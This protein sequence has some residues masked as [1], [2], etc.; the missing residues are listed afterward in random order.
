MKTYYKATRPDGTDFYSGT[1]DYAAHLKSGTPLDMKPVPRWGYHCSTET[2]YHASEVEAETL[3]GGKWPCRLFEVTGSHVVREGN[4]LGFRSLHVVREIEAWRALGPNGVDV[5]SLI[6]RARQ[7]TR[8]QLD[9]LVEARAESVE[10]ESWYAASD[11]VWDA[12]RGGDRLPAWYAAGLAAWSATR[13]PGRGVALDAARAL[14]VQDLI[15]EEHFSN[16]HGPW[17]SVVG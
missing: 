8:S 4:K 11:A 17:A 16:L 7:L 5:A 1:V 15:S 10:V 13:D 6:K 14:V 2:V 3:L 9:A 12:G